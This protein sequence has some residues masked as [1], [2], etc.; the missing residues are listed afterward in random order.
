MAKSKIPLAGRLKYK[1]I[2]QQY[3][4]S[5]DAVGAPVET[6]ADYITR[7][8]SVVPL[9]GSE[10]FAAQQLTVDMNVRIRLRY[11]TA[12]DLVTPKDRVIWNSRTFD[13]MTIINPM[14]SN[15]EIVLMCQENP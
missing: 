2:I 1:V 14:E 8:A 5:V 13:I 3:T 4:A 12:F 11:D 7:Y 6:W 15:R 10:F 9:N